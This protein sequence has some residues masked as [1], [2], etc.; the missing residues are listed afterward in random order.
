MS[1][2]VSSER[3]ARAM[4]AFS[5]RACASRSGRLV[6]GSGM[7]DHRAAIGAGDRLLARQPLQVA[8]I[9]EAETPKRSASSSTTTS[10]AWSASSS[11][12]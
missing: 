2:S 3:A 12:G 5:G 9:V 10:P 11:S 8:R 4:A 1:S 6:S 7:G